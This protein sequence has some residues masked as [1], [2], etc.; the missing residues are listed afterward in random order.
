MFCMICL[1]D[2][3]GAHPIGIPSGFPSLDK[4]T[5]G[6]VAGELIVIAGKPYTGKTT[7]AL[8]M[9]AYAAIEAFIPT[10]IISFSETETQIARRLAISI[11]SVSSHKLHGGAKLEDYEWVSLEDSLKKLAKAP[12]LIDSSC[13]LTTDD[14]GAKIQKYTREQGVCLVIIDDFQSISTPVD[15]A[16]N[17]E[18]EMT[19]ISLELKRIAREQ[20]VTIITIARLSRGST[21]AYD[22]SSSQKPQLAELKDTSSLEYDADRIIFVHPRDFL[23]MSDYP[24]D[25]DKVTLILAKN[26]TGETGEIDLLFKKE[27]GKFIEADSPLDLSSRTFIS[28]AANNPDFDNSDF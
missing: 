7:L 1:I 20:E 13:R 19:N 27:Q 4:M 24:E 11:S 23:G 10:M 8:N 2:D 12:L 21:K 5:E 17:K 9:A 18:A 22:R 15:Y 6:W 28:S 3:A 16:G 14:I 26:R 25:R